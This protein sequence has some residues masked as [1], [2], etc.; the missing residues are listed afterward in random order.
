MV[1]GTDGYVWD[2]GEAMNSR[3]PL[4]TWIPAAIVVGLVV[5][6]IIAWVVL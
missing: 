3:A 5:L 4:A 6:V 1:A 2:G